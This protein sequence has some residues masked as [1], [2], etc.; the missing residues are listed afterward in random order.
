MNPVRLAMCYGIRWILKSGMRNNL[1]KN[2]FEGGL[3]G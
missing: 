2:H 1:V 3:T